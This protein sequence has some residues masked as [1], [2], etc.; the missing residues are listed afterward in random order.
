[1]QPNT[2]PS[3]RQRRRQTLPYSLAVGLGLVWYAS[4]YAMHSSVIPCDSVSHPKHPIQSFRENGSRAPVSPSSTRYSLGLGRHTAV[5]GLGIE[6]PQQHSA[7]DT[8]ESVQYLVEHQPVVEYP[9]P[10]K[11]HLLLKESAHLTGTAP[12]G[13]KRYFVRPRRLAPDLFDIHHTCG[14]PVDVEGRVSAGNPTHFVAVAT[15]ECRRS[16]LELNTAWVEMLIHEQQ[17]NLGVSPQP[18]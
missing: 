12:M 6:Q 1:M 13:K 7:L 4:G 10:H 5:V 11:N 9:S 15:N 3:R 8:Y 18:A 17:Q 2:L 16:R 14:A